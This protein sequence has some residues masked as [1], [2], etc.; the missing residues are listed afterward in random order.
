MIDTEAGSQTSPRNRILLRILTGLA[1]LAVTALV[2]LL[3]LQGTKAACRDDG[4]D[5]GSYLLSSR[6]LLAGENPYTTGSPFPYI[7]PLFLAFAMIPFTFLAC[8][9]SAAIWALTGFAALAATLGLLN[10]RAKIP[11]PVWLIVLICLV[12]FD[13]L[14]NNIVNG[15][16]NLLVLCLCALGVFKVSR[17]RGAVAAL[18]LG[19]AAAIKLTPLILI[20]FLAVRRRWLILGG[21]VLTFI[22]LCFLPGLLPGVDAAALYREFFQGFVGEKLTGDP[23]GHGGAGFGL[24][25]ILVYLG[26]PPNSWATLTFLLLIPS[27]LMWWDHRHRDQSDLGAFGLY[28]LATLFVMPMSEIH[29]LVMALP[30]YVALA[31][32]ASAPRANVDRIILASSLLIYLAASLFWRDGPLYFMA[33]VLLTLGLLRT[34]PGESERV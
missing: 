33:L 31:A 18:V 30:A 26:L 23:G 27:G 5:L 7:Y 13:V 20:C 10:R 12:Y 1:L 24:A 25:G 17:S 14:Q 11:A 6:A 34:G 2:V 29:H 21:T 15:Q 16:T 3:F 19:A 28:L 8:Q 9:A 22:L 4:N 32:R